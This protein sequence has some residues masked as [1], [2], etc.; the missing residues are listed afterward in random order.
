MTEG[1]L[2]LLRRLRTGMLWFTAL[3]IGM[4][5]WIVFDVI[6]RD[7]AEQIVIR[8]LMGWLWHLTD[9]LPKVRWN[10]QLLAQWSGMLILLV[11][12]SHLVLLK[13][14]HSNWTWRRTL[15]TIGIPLCLIGAGGAAGMVVHHSVWLKRESFFYYDD[16]WDSTRNISNAR[17]LITALR[18]YSADHGGEYPKKLE[19]LVK[20]EILDPGEPFEK[21]THGIMQKQ[22]KIPWLVLGGLNDSAPGGLPLVVSPIPLH[23]SRYV[24]GYNDS[25]VELV[26]PEKYQAAMTAWKTWLKEHHKGRTAIPLR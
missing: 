3:I 15:L 21:L 7:R 23:G 12:T 17:Q 14:C 5:L 2:T 6:A 4:V 25:S 24:M 13:L 18:I 11:T 22:M 1:S 8:L 19:D 20:E 9:T 26:S 10:A 16:I